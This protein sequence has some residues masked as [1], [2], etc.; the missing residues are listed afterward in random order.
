MKAE[1]QREGVPDLMLAVA[2]CGY[3]G[4]F[5]EMK[6]PGGSV[7]KHQRD[8]HQKLREQGYLV[9]VVKSQ[10]AFMKVINDYLLDV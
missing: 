7:R 8:Y 10:G 1:G 9:E 3:H 2:K 5:I 4:L 6:A